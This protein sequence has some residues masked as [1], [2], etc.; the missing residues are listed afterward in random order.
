MTLSIKI[1][2]KDLTQAPETLKLPDRHLELVA[3]LSHSLMQIIDYHCSTSS[4]GSLKDAIGVTGERWYAGALVLAVSAAESL[5]RLVDWERW[6][7]NG[8]GVFTYENVELFNPQDPQEE[9]NTATRF[10][11]NLLT[12]PAWADICENCK[13]VSQPVMDMAI[14]HW[15]KRENIPQKGPA[16]QPAW[17]DQPARP[18]PPALNNQP[19]QPDQKRMEFTTG[20]FYGP[21]PQTILAWQAGNNWRFYDVAREVA[22]EFLGALP[23]SRAV[24]ARYDQGGYSPLFLSRGELERARAADVQICCEICG[25]QNVKRDAWASWDPDI[26]EWVLE[27]VFD[28]GHC[29]DCDGETSLTEEPLPIAYEVWLPTLPGP[30]TVRASLEELAE[31]RACVGA[32]VWGDINT[33]NLSDLQSSL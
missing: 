2:S 1:S 18:F 29:D 16:D 9:D 33:M 21:K 20:R 3:A 6:G 5:E 10:L 19:G 28:A 11:F 13:T 24:L 7:E 15:M 22:G 8:G 14:S 25:G 4:G 17:V 32:K 27:Q 30:V 23:N 26:Q 12:L 31:V